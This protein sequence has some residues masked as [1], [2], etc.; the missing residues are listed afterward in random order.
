MNLVEKLNR[1][2]NYLICLFL[3]LLFPSLVFSQTLVINEVMASNQ[4]TILDDYGIASDWIE[5]YNPASTT[6]D[7]S[8]YYLSDDS[9]ELRKWRFGSDS[10]KPGGYLFGDEETYTIEIK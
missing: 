1:S 8:G 10:V 7:I 2:S 6:I 5:L 4:K 9:L 3:L